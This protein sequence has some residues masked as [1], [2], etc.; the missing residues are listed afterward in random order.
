MITKEPHRTQPPLADQAAHS[1]DH[2]IKATQRVANQALDGLSG[3]CRT[4]AN[5]LRRC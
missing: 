3:T 5:R 1:A 2:A 4:C